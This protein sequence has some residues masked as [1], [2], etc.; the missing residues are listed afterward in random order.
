MSTPQNPHHAPEPAERPLSE[1]DARYSGGR[2]H[3]DDP[4]GHGADP[5]STDLPAEEPAKSG[6][7][8]AGTWLALIFGAIILILLLIFIIQNNTR[9]EFQYFG[10]QFSLPLGVAMLLAAIAGALVMG[11]VGSVRMIQ[12]SMVIRK[13]RKNEQ[14]VRQALRG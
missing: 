13:L 9:A 2:D 14:A 8:A 12:Q 7:M 10:A 3:H 4:R 11:L 1:T 6:G 5:R